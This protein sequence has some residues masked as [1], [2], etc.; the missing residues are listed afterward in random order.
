MHM[1][2][3]EYVLAYVP[4]LLPDTSVLVTHE[5]DS[6]AFHVYTEGTH[7]RHD[8]SLADGR[9]LGDVL[10]S[11]NYKQ[12]EEDHLTT[13]VDYWW[14]KIRRLNRSLQL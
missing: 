11:A 5:G 9:T 4:D 8:S 1:A 3:Y 2:K 13:D 6:Y 7:T 14:P 10:R 12:P